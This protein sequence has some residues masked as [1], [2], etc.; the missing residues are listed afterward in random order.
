M[1]LEFEPKVALWLDGQDV[2]TLFVASISLF[3]VRFG[4]ERLPHGKK[5]DIA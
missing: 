1:R 2:E 5:A 4:I 3:E